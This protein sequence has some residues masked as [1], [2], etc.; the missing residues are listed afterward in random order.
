MFEKERLN[1]YIYEYII[2]E[3]LVQDGRSIEQMPSY[4]MA[5]YNIKTTPK[6]LEEPLKTLYAAKLVKIDWPFEYEG[7]AVLNEEIIKKCWFGL[8]SLG[9]EIYEKTEPLKI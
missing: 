3:S 2:V 1:E 9:E 8:T 4:F 5:G 6:E 7:I